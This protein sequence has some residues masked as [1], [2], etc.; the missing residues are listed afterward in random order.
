M[1]WHWWKCGNQKSRK[2][3]RKKFITFHSLTLRLLN[4]SVSNS[5]KANHFV[6][7]F[8]ILKSASVPSI[9]Y[10]GRIH[11][12]PKSKI[13]SMHLAPPCLRAYPRLSKAVKNHFAKSIY[14]G[15]KQNIECHWRLAI[16]INFCKPPR[17]ANNFFDFPSLIYEFVFCLKI[18]LDIIIGACRIDTWYDTLY[19]PNNIDTVR[20]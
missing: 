9:I 14:M 19:G 20:F 15:K 16:E 1:I 17:M 7:I 13:G 3:S 4:A 18:I 6:V 11:F 5:K 12:C 10:F 8:Y 2:I